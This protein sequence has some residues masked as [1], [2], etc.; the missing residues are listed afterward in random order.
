MIDDICERASVL[1]I[2]GNEEAVQSSTNNFIMNSQVP[3]SA[4]PQV[5]YSVL[6][7]MSDLYQNLLRNFI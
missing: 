3:I 1:E 5:E 6:Q 7:G 2:S 4:A